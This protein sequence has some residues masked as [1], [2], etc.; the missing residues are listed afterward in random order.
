MST[1]REFPEKKNNSFNA[2]KKKKIIKIVKDFDL[3]QKNRIKKNAQKNNHHILEYKINKLKEEIQKQ[4]EYDFDRLMKE[5]KFLYEKNL[6][7]KEK[8]KNLMIQEEKWKE[9]L[10][11]MKQ[12]RNQIFKE[13]KDK[14]LSRI[15]N[16]ERKKKND[17]TLSKSKSR[18]DIHSD[19]IIKKLKM[20]QLPILNKL[21]KCE[22]IKKI[23]AKNEEEFC[24]RTANL[25]KK[26]DII[27]KKNYLNHFKI[28]SNK[29]IKQN[30]LHKE[31]SLKCLFSSKHLDENL[32]KE[33]I[34]K[35]MLKRYHA[36]EHIIN[37]YTNK[38]EKIKDNLNQK[39]EEASR[40]R[41]LLYSKEEEK[42]NSYIKKLNKSSINKNQ[43]SERRK[44]IK[45][46]KM[47]RNYYA[48]LQKE[49]FGNIKNNEQDYFEYLS[50]K[51]GDYI[52]HV[53]KYTIDESKIKT[54]IIKK[55]L[56]DDN[57]KEQSFRSLDNYINKMN[58]R[59][60][61]GLT[62]EEQRKIFKSKLDVEVN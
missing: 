41:E 4:N 50:S 2:V 44:S 14:L 61:Y 23:K 49:N 25:L 24:N 21:S 12:Y 62:E 18:I 6:K 52:C 39:F 45:A 1:I 28:L 7:E 11:N 48:K 56:D 3:L 35:D 16:S 36:K 47:R 51:R 34:K 13:K 37:E 40:K 32:E 9:K 59:N 38:V 29:F 5:M 15:K 55:T 17:R 27:H 19:A 10:E 42:I 33:Y 26:Q 43:M 20:V 60:I 57:F 31:R 22:I 46:K 30:Q 58:K 8:T 53:K 54:K